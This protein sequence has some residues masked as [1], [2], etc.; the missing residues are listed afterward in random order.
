MDFS[1]KSDGHKFTPYSCVHIEVLHLMRQAET[2]SLSHDREDLFHVLHTIWRNMEMVWPNF[3][4]AFG[5]R[6]S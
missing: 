5:F 6:V 4:T 3:V 1:L 2:R